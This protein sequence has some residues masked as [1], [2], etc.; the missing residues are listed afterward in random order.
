ML[1]LLSYFACVSV[2]VW[3]ECPFQNLNQIKFT[4]KY[5]ERK[6][7][8]ISIFLLTSTLKKRRGKRKR[9]EGEW[10]SR[11]GVEEGTN[12]L[13]V[14]CALLLWKHA[15]KMFKANV[16]FLVKS[17]SYTPTHISSEK[18]LQEAISGK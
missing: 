10:M 14:L 13:Q 4:K 15:G 11:S 16:Q 6:H 9:R 3:S 5:R 17:V 18:P 7:E 2:C 8:N 1:D 12:E